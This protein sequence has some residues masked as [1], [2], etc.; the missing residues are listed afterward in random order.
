MNEER[1]DLHCHTNCSDGTLTPREILHLA[2]SIGLTGISITDH[3]TIAAYDTAP[4][5]A[6]ALGI[7]LLT[8]VEFSA[9]HKGTSIHILGYGFP[10][11]AP[12]IA[13][14]CQR[15]IVRRGHRNALILEL[16]KKHKMP[17]SVEDVTLPFSKSLSTIGRPHIAQAMVTKGYVPTIS[18]AFKKYIGEERPCYAAGTPHSIEVTLEAIHAAQGVAVIAHPHLINNGAILDAILKMN[19]D[20]IECYYGNF[21][22]QRNT[23]WLEIAKKKKWLITGGSDFHGD[24]KPAQTLGSSWI[25]GELFAQIQ[26]RTR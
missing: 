13:E 21:T 2:K 12:T 16:L 5:I 24:M 23:R 6:T 9:S 19:F 15:H 11:T 17:L 7:T 3:D 1:Y 18:D 10:I 22:N 26:E 14:L 25:N 4:E 8:G 20:G